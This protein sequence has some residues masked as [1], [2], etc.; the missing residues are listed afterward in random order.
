[1]E[2]QIIII[3]LPRSI[4]FELLNNIIYLIDICF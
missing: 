3:L 1:M 2:N 4:K